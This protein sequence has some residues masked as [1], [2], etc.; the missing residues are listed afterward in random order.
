MGLLPNSIEVSL[1][2]NC[3]VHRIDKSFGNSKKYVKKSPLPDYNASISW[4]FMGRLC[5][6]WF[7]PCTTEIESYIP[8]LE[9]CWQ[10]M[11]YVQKIQPV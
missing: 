9:I 4:M 2:S 6:A 1:S 11:T 8:A 5:V 7:A 10:W 3:L